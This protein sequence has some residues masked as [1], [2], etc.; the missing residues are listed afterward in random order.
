MK[1]ARVT[2]ENAYG[3]ALDRLT[4]GNSIPM[5]PEA[6]PKQAIPDPLPL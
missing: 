3:R 5:T 1:R 4:G 6:Q 2:E